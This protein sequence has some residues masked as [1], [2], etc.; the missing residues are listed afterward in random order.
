MPTTTYLASQVY[1]GVVPSRVYV[2]D[3]LI[4]PS[5]VSQSQRAV[6]RVTLTSSDWA[7]SRLFYVQSRVT[8]RLF[9]EGKD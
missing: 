9:E 6:V 7:R 5:R 3:V 8:V 1:F 2:G 4:L